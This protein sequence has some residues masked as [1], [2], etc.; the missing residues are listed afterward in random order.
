MEG[1]LGQLGIDWKLLLSQG[2]NFF[3]LLLVL[4]QFVYKPLMV[5]IKKRT[6]KIREG[7]EKAKE[8]D[9]RLKEIDTIGKNKLKHADQQAMDIIKN[10]EERAKALENTLKLKAEAHQKELMAQIALSADRQ[11]EEAR[12]NVLKGASEL[13]KKFIVKTVE[14]RPEAIDEALIKKAVAELKHEPR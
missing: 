1:L 12:Q 14:L 13:V 6:E 8:A 3:I 2:V 7:L 10:T 5:V 4:R 9:V 11:K